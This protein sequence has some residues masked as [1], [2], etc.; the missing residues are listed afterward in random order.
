MSID[1]LDFIGYMGS[2]THTT[3]S[4]KYRP[5]ILYIVYGCYDVIKLMDSCDPLRFGCA[6]HRAEA[7]QGDI[8]DLN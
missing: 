3:L 4:I 1:F 2:Y 5:Y 6:S 8:S 7:R